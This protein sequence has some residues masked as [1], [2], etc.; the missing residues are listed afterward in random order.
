MQQ[1]VPKHSNM[2]P[3][4]TNTKSVA[5]PYSALLEDSSLFMV[6]LGSHVS[7]GSGKC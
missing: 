6:P 4:E 3:I 5:E 1:A 7:W 2:N